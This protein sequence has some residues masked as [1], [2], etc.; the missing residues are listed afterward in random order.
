M[1]RR[2]RQA[3][4]A[5]SPT[6]P[7][8]RQRGWGGGGFANYLAP[9][10]STLYWNNSLAL[11]TLKASSD[12]Q[13]VK[14]KCLTAGW[15]WPWKRRPEIL[16]DDV[17]EDGRQNRLPDKR[18]NCRRMEFAKTK[19]FK[20]TLS[21]RKTD[22]GRWLFAPRLFIFVDPRTKEERRPETEEKNIK[23]AFPI[24]SAPWR[25]C[26][27]VGGGCGCGCGG[28]GGAWSPICFC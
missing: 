16:P 10:E 28:V 26:A 17:R 21:Q 15:T 6:D 2:L 24:S 27:W 7:V 8:Q 5:T 25:V 11:L 13:E 18:E 14:T 12:I 9:N 1:E 20:K 23:S 22:E 19:A 3:G 4:V